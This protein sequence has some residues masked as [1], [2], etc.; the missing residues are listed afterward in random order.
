MVAIRS[1]QR[2]V[3]DRA[4]FMVGA[5][6]VRVET[7]T[8]EL[9]G[10]LG[11][12]CAGYVPGGSEP[13][14]RA[15]VVVDLGAAPTEGLPELPRLSP[16]ADG[17]TLIDVSEGWSLTLSPA[18]EGPHATAH[19][20]RWR[21]YPAL[22][23]LQLEGLVRVV[24]ATLAPGAAGALI[25]GCAMVAPAGDRAAL[26]IGAS[27]DGKTTMTRRLPG[28][29]PLADDTAWIGRDGSGWVVAGTPFAGKE[30]LPLSG[31]Q[32]P[33]AG[34]FALAPAEPLALTR[35]GA[36]PAFF[37]L[38]S[39]ALWFAPAWSGTQALWDLLAAVADAVPVWRLASGLEDDVAPVVAAAIDRA[40]APCS[41]G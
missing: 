5:V 36:A 38:V 15:R 24:A 20:R 14:V 18:L 41:V 22:W 40:E 27:G 10:P 37:A 6:C 7:C 11:D 1:N 9:R 31:D 2:A 8:A 16:S 3:T 21:E 13:A 12:A 25:H 34:I 32:I 39:R 26:F 17:A 35:L 23:R 29:R 19:L 28:W 30:R 4:D 33:L